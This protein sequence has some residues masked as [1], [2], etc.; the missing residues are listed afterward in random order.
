[1]PRR[2]LRVTG[3]APYTHCTAPP[4]PLRCLADRCTTEPLPRPGRHPLHLLV[5]R[6]VASVTLFSDPGQRAYREPRTVPCGKPLALPGPF[7]FDLD[8]SDFL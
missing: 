4:A 8:T 6:D 7:G 1:M 3:A 5:D 2:P